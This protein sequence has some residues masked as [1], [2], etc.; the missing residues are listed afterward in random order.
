MAT[1]ALVTETTT[2]MVPGTRGL[3]DTSIIIRASV[4]TITDMAINHAISV[5][6]ITL[7]LGFTS[8]PTE[9]ES[10]S[11]SPFDAAQAVGIMVAPD[12]SF[13]RQEVKRDSLRL[14]LVQ[15]H[16][17]ASP[18]VFLCQLPIRIRV[19]QHLSTQTNQC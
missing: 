3:T 5:I 7:I 15:D 9:Q 2:K 8:L 19:P 16:C 11:D 13:C 14:C 10:R 1:I 17:R 18:L 6:V 12:F 4:I